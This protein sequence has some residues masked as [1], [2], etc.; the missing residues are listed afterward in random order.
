MVGP[1]LPASIRTTR[2]TTAVGIE[3]GEEDYTV[4]INVTS[5]HYTYRKEE[6]EQRMQLLLIFDLII[7]GC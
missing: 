7:Y 6:D 3:E 4:F 2:T 1:S 5:I